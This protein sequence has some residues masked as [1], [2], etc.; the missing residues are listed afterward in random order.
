M[1]I[2]MEFE[3]SYKFCSKIETCKWKVSFAVCA[4]LTFRFITA[5][6]TFHFGHHC[7][8]Y[9]RLAQKRLRNTPI[10][11]VYSK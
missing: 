3:D 4:K 9:F 11:L 8:T 1:L 2:L 7:K 6:L 10:M 5:K